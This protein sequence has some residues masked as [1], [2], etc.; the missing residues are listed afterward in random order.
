[1]LR[2]I[3]NKSWK[4]HPSK[5][6]LY[7]YLPPISKTI[8]IRR[9]RHTGHCWRSKDGL[10]SD[11]QLWT[12][13]HGR[14]RTGWP[15]RTY[16]QPLCSDTRCSL[17]DMPEAMD[18]T[19][20]WRLREREREL[21]KSVLAARHDDDDGIYI[22]IFVCVCVCAKIEEDKNAYFCMSAFVYIYIYIYICL[23]AHISS[24]CSLLVSCFQFLL[25]CT[26]SSASASIPSSPPSTY[27]AT[28]ARE[29]MYLIDSSRCSSSHALTRYAEISRRCRMATPGTRQG[30]DSWQRGR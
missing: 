11:I 13:S 2:P 20:R 17:E 23:K 3:L 24:I 25:D 4:Q 9:T 6:Q 5:Q 14:A 19:D 1:M 28:P 29:S 18:D 8:K 26:C 12:S 27:P 15:G 10:I 7:G 16:L 30:T 22:Y 21:G